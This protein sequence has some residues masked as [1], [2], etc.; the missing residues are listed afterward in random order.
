MRLRQPRP[1][2]LLLLLPALRVLATSVAVDTSD[3]RLPARAV[4]PAYTQ[5]T[6][7]PDA[8][9]APT[10]PAKGT[11]DAPFDGLDG[12]PH[13]GPYVDDDPKYKGKK[14]PNVVED[15][16]SA[17]KPGASS[18]TVLVD[19]VKDG[20]KSVMQDP[21]R[22]LATGK[23]GV[24]GG[25]SAKDKERLAHEDKTGS[26]KEQVPTAPKEAPPLPHG[27]QSHLKEAASV[28]ASSTR[29]AGAVGLE[30]SMSPTITW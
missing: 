13:A 26:K 16:G 11:K 9:L 4:V 17:K 8:S 23:T 19:D 21:D 25:V 29:L 12:K 24:E 10:A 22:K 7:S 2:T 5:A 18:E 14:A 3:D 28:V 20:D 27:E 1:H 6:Y 30:V 15:L